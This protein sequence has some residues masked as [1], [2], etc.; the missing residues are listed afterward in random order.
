MKY[1]SIQSV[2][3][4]MEPPG[5]EANDM[6]PFEMEGYQPDEQNEQYERIGVFPCDYSFAS[7]FHLS[8][9]S[10][11][12]FTEKN[13]DTEGAGEYII[14]EAAM[15]RLC[16]SDPE[17]I[18]GKE[19]KLI[20][21]QG[22]QL[23]ITIPQGKIIGVVNDFYLSSLKKEVEPLVLFKRDKLWLLNFVVAFQPRQQKEAIADMRTVWNKLFPEYPFQYEPVGAMYEKVY[24]AELLQAKLLS[25]FTIIALFICSMGLF[26]L[27]LIVTQQRTKEIGV[28]KVNGAKVSEIL[29]M[30]NKDFIKWIAVSFVVATPIAWFA[31]NKWLENFA[32]KTTL[33]WWVFALA[34]ALALGIAL[35]TVSFQSWKAASQNPVEA[36][37]YE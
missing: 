16:Y 9:L 19:F 14:N 12:N 34:G 32:Y 26:G 33:S 29:N 22:E 36:L 24:K 27:A 2:S 4:M 10:G 3:A 35:L 28:R 8:F 1:N 6:F 31:M 15:K 17:K 13:L 23:A 37:R 18:V 7:L 11:Q 25:V 20:F 5:G 21:E 30:L